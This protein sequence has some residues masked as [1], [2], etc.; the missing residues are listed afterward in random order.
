MPATI[1]RLTHGADLRRF[2]LA[3]DAAFSDRPTEDQIVDLVALMEPGRNYVAVDGGNWVGTAGSYAFDMSVPG[4]ALVPTAGVTMVGVQP[5]HRR[6]GVLRALMT[7]QLQDIA[8]EG[9]P[10]ALLWASEPTIYG[11]FGYGLAS[12]HAHIDIERVHARLAEPVERTGSLRLVQSEEAIGLFSAVY[13][14]V[15]SEVP[16]LLARDERWWRYHRLTDHPDDRRGSGPLFAAVLEIGG[17]PEGYALYRV[18]Q[19]WEHGV[20]NGTLEVAEAVATS[21]QA[22][23]ELWS[24]LF[25]IDLVAKVSAWQL[26]GDHVLLDLAADPRRLRWG[27]SDGL[28]LRIADLPAALAARRYHGHGELVLEVRD[29]L[30]PANH[31]RWRLVCGAG[32]GRAERTE[33]GPDLSLDIAALGAIYLGGRSPARLAAAGMIAERT[34]GAARRA[35]QL[36]YSER[37]PYCP[38]IW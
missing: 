25:G 21:L 22:T 35:E 15:L 12:L 3:C 24:F 16:G 5:T 2:L 28:W 4:G 27:L 14:K 36:F 19:D 31:G 26:P 9:E 6:R 17:R 29:E 20:P 8:A 33:A 34:P 11:R 13:D 38:E 1:Q 30:L 32:E 10:L 18:R 37:L 7:R 23:K